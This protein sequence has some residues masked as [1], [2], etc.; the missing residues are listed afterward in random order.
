MDKKVNAMKAKN[1]AA[2]RRKTAEEGTSSSC[3]GRQL[4]TAD[5]AHQKSYLLRSVDNLK[6]V[7]RSLW[8]RS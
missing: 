8:E 7:T 2:E 4:P 1:M 5:A 6:E 3:A